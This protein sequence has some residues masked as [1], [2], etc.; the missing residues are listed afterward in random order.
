MATAVASRQTKS[1]KGSNKELRHNHAFSL[2]ATKQK[3]RFYKFDVPN[4][5]RLLLAASKFIINNLKLN[6]F[7]CNYVTVTELLLTTRNVLCS[8]VCSA[9]HYL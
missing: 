9:A 7:N 6:V 1:V 3:V 5:A 2:L 4:T 8:L